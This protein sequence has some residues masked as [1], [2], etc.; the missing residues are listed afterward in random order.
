MLFE[1]YV[2]KKYRNLAVIIAHYVSLILNML[3]ARIYLVEIFIVNY[4]DHLIIFRSNNKTLPLT[5]L[6][7]FLKINL[8]HG[9]LP[10]K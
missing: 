4:Q 3:L 10:L 1:N 6:L 2:V 7:F 5:V 9:S 8:T